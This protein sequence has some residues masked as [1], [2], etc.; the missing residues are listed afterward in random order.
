[1]L[2]KEGADAQTLKRIY[3]AVVQAV[4]LYGPE[5]WVMTPLIGMF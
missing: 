1:M 5:M 3:G 4:I 2:S